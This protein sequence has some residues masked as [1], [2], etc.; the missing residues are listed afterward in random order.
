MKRLL[1][2]ILVVLSLVGSGPA[3]AESSRD[4]AMAGSMPMGDHQKM[5]CC[6]PDCA[7]AAPSA[8]LPVA[9]VGVLDLPE[10]PAP[11]LAPAAALHSINPAA[12]DPPPRTF[13]S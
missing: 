2:A 6:T 7:V 8:V 1:I 9:E 4:C 12:T 3:F 11:A 13:I 5:G 10:A